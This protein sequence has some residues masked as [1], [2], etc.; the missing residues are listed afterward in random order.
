MS[1]HGGL[2]STSWVDGQSGNPSGLRKDG[3][4]R[5]N[6]PHRQRYTDI[7]ILARQCCPEAIATLK[8]LMLSAK[9]APS[10]RIQAASILLDRGYGRPAQRVDIQAIMGAIDLTRLTDGQL[11]QM[12]A[13]LARCRTSHRAERSGGAVG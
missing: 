7:K 13:N 1:G 11:E 3:L 6:P 8:K 5:R 2:R 10:A 12:E 9:V 4:P